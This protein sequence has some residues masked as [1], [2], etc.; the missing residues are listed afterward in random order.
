MNAYCK[1]LSA[2]AA[3]WEVQKQK[4]HRAVSEKVMKD[5]EASSSK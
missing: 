2:D 1:S 3:A 4:G 5:L